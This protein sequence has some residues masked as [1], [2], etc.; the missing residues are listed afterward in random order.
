MPPRSPCLDDNIMQNMP[1]CIGQKGVV[2][3]SDFRAL[4]TPIAG[5]PFRTDQVWYLDGR[6]VDPPNDVRL[7]VCQ[8]QEVHSSVVDPKMNS[9][10]SRVKHVLNDVPEKLKTRPKPLRL[11]GSRIFRRLRN[12]R[13][14][15]YKDLDQN[16]DTT[17][18]DE[19]IDKVN[20][21]QQDEQTEQAKR[22]D[23]D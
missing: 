19:K 17:L 15:Y 4:D 8:P 22:N 23:D 21:S 16:A 20:E 5:R 14:S 6:T 11:N 2:S 10:S 12:K 3:G 7:P 1:G 18:I 13:K 9:R